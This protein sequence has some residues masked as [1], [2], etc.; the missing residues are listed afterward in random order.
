MIPVY[1]MFRD[2]GWL[3]TFKPLLHETEHQV[4]RGDAEIGLQELERQGIQVTT[5]GRTVEQDREF[6][7]AGSASGVVAAEVLRS[8]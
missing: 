4:R 3:N 8:Q 1:L 2:A 5:M 7:L 6:F